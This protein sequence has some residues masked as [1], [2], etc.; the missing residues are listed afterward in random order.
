M[1]A[2]AE[3][4]SAGGLG[5]H[6]VPGELRLRTLVQGLYPFSPW[7][8]R[9]VAYTRYGCRGGSVAVTMTSDPK[10]FIS[11]K[12]WLRAR[13]GRVRVVR[14]VAPSRPVSTRI[15]AY[16]AGASAWIEFTVTP[17]PTLSMPAGIGAASV[18]PAVRFSP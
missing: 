18:R 8:G 12:T 5:L 7:S 6:R 13:G 11:P 3:L 16:R 10:L 15:R 2:G 1:P 4:G 17:A 14:E 9:H